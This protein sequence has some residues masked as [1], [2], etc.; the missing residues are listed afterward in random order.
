MRKVILIAGLVVGAGNFVSAAMPYFNTAEGQTAPAATKESSGWKFPSLWGKKD[1]P[2]NSQFFG[3]APEKVP[4]ASE[5]FASAVTD[6]AVVKTARRWM[7][8]KTAKDAAKKPDPISLNYPTGKPTPALLVAMAQVREQTADAAGARLLYQQALAAG[9]KNVNTL[10]EWGH[11][12]DRQGKLADAERYYAEASNLE[13]QNAG[14]LNDLA[15]CLARQGKVQASADVLGKAVQLEPSKAL[16]RNNM[17]TVLMELGKQH[18]A[19]HQLMAVHSPAA[20]YYNMGHLLEKGKQHEAAAAHYAE[21]VRLD[22]KMS[23]AQSALARLTPAA[24]PSITQ[25]AMA[26]KVV[27]PEFGPQTSWSS[28]PLSPVAPT[29][30]EPEFGPRLLPPVD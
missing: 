2:A 17:A 25:T 5:R 8:P 22:P 3:A 4:S 1:K 11:F 26:A 29:T 15:L 14:V 9:P 7:T 18:E 16:Y 28:E 19:M 20:A 12:E 23:P 30:P 10:H 13:P 27:E 6:N 21:A 24:M